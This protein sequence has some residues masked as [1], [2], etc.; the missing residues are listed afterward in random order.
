MPEN[1]SK[2]VVEWLTN[3]E[4]KNYLSDVNF[5]HH[6]YVFHLHPFSGIFIFKKNIHIRHQGL[7]HFLQFW[8]RE[9]RWKWCQRQTYFHRFNDY[10]SFKN[11]CYYLLWLLLLLLFFILFIILHNNDDHYFKLSAYIFSIWY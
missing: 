5:P 8:L 2:N 11:I 6:Y 4:S 7:C 3:I 10:G 1:W 9:W